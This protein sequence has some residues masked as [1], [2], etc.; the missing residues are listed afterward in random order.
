[1]ARVKRAHYVC[2]FCEDFS[3][4]DVEEL[5]RG[6]V[7]PVLGGSLV[8]VVLVV[9]VLRG[10]LVVVAVVVVLGG[11]LVVVAV[12]VV[13]AGIVVV[14]P[15]PPMQ[16]SVMVQGSPVAVHSVWQNCLQ[17]FRWHAS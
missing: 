16:G 4:P 13:H 10:W 6:A 11:W 12:V 3:F 7:V 14:L 17:S 2:F 15:D 9:T 5:L 8:V 1:M